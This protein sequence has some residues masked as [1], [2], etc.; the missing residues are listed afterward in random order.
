MQLAAYAA[1][2]AVLT[3][4]FW[5]VFV[6]VFSTRGGGPLTSLWT[7]TL[8]RVLLLTHRRAPIHRLLS[9]AGPFM[10]L[11][12]ILV[13][14]GVLDVGWYL[15]FAADPASVIVSD[16]GAA[17]TLLQKAYFVGSTV[18][19]LGYGDFVPSRFPWTIFSNIASLSGTIIVTASLSYVLT[20]LSAGVERK[21]LAE[22][23]FGVGKTVPEFIRHVW[24]GKSKGA[25]DNHILRLASDIDRH[26]HK[27][28]SYPLLHFFH[29]PD[30]TQSPSR[31]VL[32]FSDA[33]FL[34]NHGVATGHQPPKGM[35]RVADSSF[36]NYADFADA[37]LALPGHVDREP[38]EY[39]TVGTLRELGL[40]PASEPEFQQELAAYASR[41]DRLI[42]VCQGDGW[43]ER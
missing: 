31:A 15:L 19:G 30:P 10:L 33:M 42:A 27:H 43:F 37:G 35:S 32:L 2:V 14:Y 21:Y 39:L 18:S 7:R 24:A 23:I 12:V 29:S 26:A 1:A 40:P 41:R 4:G 3:L 22:G 38:P 25:L 6:T 34:M 20:V 9:Y 13:W 16:T 17:A 36:E 11:S 28:L 5:D 8:W